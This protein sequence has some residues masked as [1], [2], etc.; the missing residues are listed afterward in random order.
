ML[1]YAIKKVVRFLQQKN[2]KAQ[3]NIA[4]LDLQST[5]LSPEASKEGLER[6]KTNATNSACDPNA[7]FVQCNEVSASKLCVK[8]SLFGDVSNIR[9]ISESFE[10]SGKIFTKFCV[11]FKP[12]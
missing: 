11:N 5:T 7:K 10:E 12:N 4:I 8:L 6:N 2:R 9:S 1:Y 3:L